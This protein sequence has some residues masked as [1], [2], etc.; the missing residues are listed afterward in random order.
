MICYI[1]SENIVVENLIMD[2]KF[3]VPGGINHGAANYLQ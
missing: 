3:T 2:Y 1:L